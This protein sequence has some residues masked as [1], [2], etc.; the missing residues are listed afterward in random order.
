MKLK[1]LCFLTIIF[2]GIVSCSNGKQFKQPNLLYIFPDQMRANTLGFMGKEPVL[3]PN[4]DLFAR[5]GIVLSNAASNA[6]VCSPY[7][8]MLMTGRYPV[9]NG[10]VSNTTNRMALLDMQLKE[11]EYCWSGKG[12]CLCT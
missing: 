8:A 11:S 6:P 3:T 12:E 1:S 9:S 10:V 7:R 2:T 4:L 5:E